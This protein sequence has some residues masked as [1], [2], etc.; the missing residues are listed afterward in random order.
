MTS[1]SGEFHFG[2]DGFQDDGL[3][4]SYCRGSLFS[5]LLFFLSAVRVRDT[6]SGMR[7][8]RRRC[9]NYLLPLP[10]ALHFTPAMTARATVSNRPR[11]VEA[12]MSYSE[13]EGTSKLSVLM[14]GLRFL[15]IILE[16]TFL[17]RP[18][19]LFNIIATLA[20]A[21]ALVMMIE[22]SHFYLSHQRVE[23]WMIYRFVASHL[24][25][26]V[27]FCHYCGSYL[28]YRIVC[29]AL[30]ETLS[31]GS[32]HGLAPLFESKW[33]LTVPAIFSLMKAELVL[34]SFMDLV[35]TGHVCEHWSR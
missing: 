33:K 20:T 28:S 6:A 16:T 14:D 23:E 17:Y 27:A 3:R 4:A 9:L 31:P 30:K 1:F 19:R 8:I 26:T 5:I 10:T 22:P 18:A 12:D 13:R 29:L 32:R 15:R 21:L 34:P 25:G 24:C 2:L 35:Q 7:I 11:L